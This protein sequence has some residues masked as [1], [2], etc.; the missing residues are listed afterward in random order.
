MRTGYNMIDGK[1]NAVCI[2]RT[3]RYTWLLLRDF[4]DQGE[5]KRMEDGS[6]FFWSDPIFLHDFL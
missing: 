4:S 1:S 6:H 5:D 3:F 2:T